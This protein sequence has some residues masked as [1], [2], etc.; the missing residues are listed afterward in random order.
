MKQ[1]FEEMDVAIQDSAHF[2]RGHSGDQT[3]HNWKRHLHPLME[4]TD[5]T[6]YKIVDFMTDELH[7]VIKRDAANHPGR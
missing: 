4:K 5:K 7:A 6:I 2:W 1:H 3:R